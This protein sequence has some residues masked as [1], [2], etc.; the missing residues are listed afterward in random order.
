MLFLDVFPVSDPGQDADFDEDDEH[1]DDLVAE[2][3]GVHPPENLP[4][5]TEVLPSLPQPGPRPLQRLPLTAQI[6]DDLVT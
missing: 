3:V 6:C 5:A 2:Y 1:E 4:A